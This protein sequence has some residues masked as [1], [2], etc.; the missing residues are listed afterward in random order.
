MIVIFHSPF[1]NHNKLVR[2]WVDRLSLGQMQWWASWLN[3]YDFCFIIN[4]TDC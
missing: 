1:I 2:M 3:Q 4:T